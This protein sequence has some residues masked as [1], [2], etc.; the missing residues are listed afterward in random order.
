MHEG[1]INHQFQIQVSDIKSFESYLIKL[2]NR[3]ITS[4]KTRT[5][6]KQTQTTNRNSSRS[7]RRPV[8]NPR[9]DQIHSP[10]T[11]QRES[12][13]NLTTSRIWMVR[14]A[15]ETAWRDR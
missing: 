6:S 2:R 11:A 9:S 15:S 4:L 7:I 10:S 3:K 13:L 1:N 12:V 14:K 8:K 5:G